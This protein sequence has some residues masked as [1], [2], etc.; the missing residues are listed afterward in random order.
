MW[1]RLVSLIMVLPVFLHSP[2]VDGQ[3]VH[4]DVGLP[5][6][7]EGHYDSRVDIDW[8][9]GGVSILTVLMAIHRI[10]PDLENRP[11][12]F[13]SYIRE[14]NCPRSQH[15]YG[16]ADFFFLYTGAKD[17]CD[18]WTMYRDDIH[19][20]TLWLHTL[21]IEDR[22]GFGIYWHR[23]MHLDFRGKKARWG[24]DHTG[25]QISFDA[26]MELIDDY[27]THFC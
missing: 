2:L 5:L 12:Q 6:V 14:Q 23:A 4:P 1:R 27:I 10:S 24:F 21:G 7:W 9:T 13:T 15:C 17:E 19:T 3:A 16:A 22:V 20:M 18:Y 11:P 8:D 25:H 26:M